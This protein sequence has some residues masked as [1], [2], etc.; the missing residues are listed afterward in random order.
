[1]L[2][3]SFDHPVNNAARKTNIATYM[4]PTVPLVPNKSGKTDYGGLYGQRITTRIDTNNGVFVYNQPFKFR[5]I[6]D[7]L[8]STAVVAEDT[9][10]PDGEWINGYNIFEQSGGINDP[11]AWVGDNEIRSHHKHG[12][13]VLFACG[14][15]LFIPN[16]CDPRVL[17][18]MITRNAGDEWT[19]LEAGL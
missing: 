17:A 7:G 8:S 10:G 9:G 2:F 15:V 1:M 6:R 12:A 16:S 18:A 3:R 5:D 14:R 19:N 4:C 11:K 13:M